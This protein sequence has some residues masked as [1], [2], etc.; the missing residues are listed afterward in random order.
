MWTDSFRY[1]QN[2]LCLRINSVIFNCNTSCFGQTFIVMTEMW[3]KDPFFFSGKL[4]LINYNVY[5]CDRSNLS[6]SYSRGGSVLIV[7][8]KDIPS[9]LISFS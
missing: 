7:V 6:R 8:R 5:R 4:G 2:Y 3:L 9:S 1:Y